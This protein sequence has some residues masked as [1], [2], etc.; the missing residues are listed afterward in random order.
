MKAVAKTRPAPGID[1]LEVEPLP[2]SAD[3]VLVLIANLTTA[4]DALDGYR[5]AVGAPA[6]GRKAPAGASAKFCGGCGAARAAGAR[7][8]DSCGAPFADGA[9]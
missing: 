7:F 5:A 2:L 9:R 8:C 1:L 3:D 4:P 6:L